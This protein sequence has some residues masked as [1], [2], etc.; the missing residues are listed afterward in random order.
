[1]KQLKPVNSATQL[2]NWGDY[3]T[4][5]TKMGIKARGTG[6][7]SV[8]FDHP[9]MAGTVVKVFLDGD[10]GY[11]YYLNWVTRNQRNPY[12]P[13]LHESPE[14]SKKR[15]AEYAPELENLGTGYSIAFLEKL[16]PC[17][18]RVQYEFLTMVSPWLVAA[19]YDR[20]LRGF[21]RLSRIGIRGWKILVNAPDADVASLAKCFVGGEKKHMFLDLGNSFNTMQRGQQL[22][23]TDPF[24]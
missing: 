20:G 5:L 17:D 1:M 9:T 18:S 16:Q 11:A 22:V 13:K 19:G 23:F 15:H 3:T 7:N 24:I 21:D 12:A 2:E 10:K 6:A 14:Y 4:R 8:V